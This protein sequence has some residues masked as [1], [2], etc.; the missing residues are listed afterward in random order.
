M[1]F[2]KDAKVRTVVNKLE[3]LNNVYRTPI[4]E[5]IAGKHNFETEH[6]EGGLR[7][8]LD[9]EKVYW[10]S[11]LHSERERV[12]KTLKNGEVICDAFCGIGPFALRA[13]KE[14]KSRVF[15]SDLNPECF[16]YL[17]ENIKINKLGDLVT[18]DCKDARVFIYE[19]LE[20][21]F[22]GEIEKIDHFYMNLPAD[23]L[24]FLDVFPKFFTENS[25]YL[26]QWDLYGGGL[27]H[28]YCFVTQSDHQGRLRQVVDR[29]SKVMP[30]VK[31]EDVEGIHSLK[32]V[33]SEKEM[34]CV[35]LRLTKENCSKVGVVEEV[36]LKKRA[37]LEENE[38]K[39]DASGG[40][41]ENGDE[42][43]EAGGVSSKKLKD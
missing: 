12:L 14:A 16:K 1:I 36:L 26:N 18:P 10:C 4:L 25:H 13:A 19:T 3:K 41:E 29:V 24:E 20:A 2:D 31:E 35:S 40:E 30:G 34:L 22:K 7:F 21:S 42:G 28:V 5:L 17:K 8:R 23:G 11:R 9:F 43:I 15:A 27:V 39:E 6:L 32:T 37:E 33:S 38:Q